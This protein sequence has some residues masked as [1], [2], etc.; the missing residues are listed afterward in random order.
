MHQASVEQA[1]FILALALTLESEN[2]KEEGMGGGLFNR[3]PPRAPRIKSLVL[4][5]SYMVTQKFLTDIHRQPPGDSHP[6]A[7]ELGQEW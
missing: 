6:R 4:R 3:N 7:I 1:A 2:F 5:C